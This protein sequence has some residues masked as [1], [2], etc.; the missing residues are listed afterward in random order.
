MARCPVGRCRG[1]LAERLKIVQTEGWEVPPE[2]RARRCACAEQHQSPGKHSHTSDG[3]HV[4]RPRRAGARR[5]VRRRPAG[6]RFKCSSCKV[7][8]LYDQT[9]AADPGRGIDHPDKA[10]LQQLAGR[11]GTRA[12]T[13]AQI[14]LRRFGAAGTQPGEH[15]TQ[16]GTCSSRSQSRPNSPPTAWMAVVMLPCAGRLRRKALQPNPSCMGQTPLRVGCTCTCRLHP[17]SLLRFSKPNAS[18]AGRNKHSLVSACDTPVANGVSERLDHTENGWTGKADTVQ[19]HASDTPAT[20]AY[21]STTR[22][23]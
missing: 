3:A 4:A 19:T 8:A 10:T 16:A 15:K 23:G 17:P 5:H 9:T 1:N 21:G 6:A 11:E 18:R 13:P 2:S 12:A 7:G 20:I 22:G 14:V